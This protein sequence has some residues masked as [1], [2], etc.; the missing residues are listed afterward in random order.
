MVD[1][2]YPNGLTIS[3]AQSS[4][5]QRDSVLASKTQGY[6]AVGIPLLAGRENQA[7]L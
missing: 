4:P 7:L 1:S 2:R 3:T 5:V 6:E